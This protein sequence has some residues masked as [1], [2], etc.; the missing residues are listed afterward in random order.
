MA[1]RVTSVFKVCV[2][3][4]HLDFFD[5]LAAAIEPSIGAR[6][7]VPFR[8]KT[9]L[10]I[11]VGRGAPEN[12]AIVLKSIIEVIDDTPLLTQDMLALCQWMSRYYQSSLSE[13]IPLALPKKYRRGD[14]R[15]LPQCDYYALIKPP[16]EAHQQLGGRAPK[17]HALIDFMATHASPVSKKVLSQAGFN[18]G[19]R[20]ALCA[21]GIL[22]LHSQPDIPIMHHETTGLALPLNDEQAFAVNAITKD[23]DA[24]R[25][26]LL[27]GV[28]GSG[29]TEVY[30]QV[31]ARVLAVNRQV[32]VLLPEIGLTPQLL[33]R[34]TARFAVPMAVIHSHLNDT[35][36]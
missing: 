24:Y 35:E 20:L 21:A 6:V 5:Y 23:L 8:S 16:A 4:A 34:F 9:R 22:S 7:W 2:P 33:E 32:L 36:R 27:Q 29:K 30:L 10:G 14:A 18:T 1:A 3:H 19:Q 25:C 26:F 15:Q 31:I 17:Q 12:P 13:I 28:T 11:V